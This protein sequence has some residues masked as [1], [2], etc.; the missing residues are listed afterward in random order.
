[1]E[2]KVRNVPEDVGIKLAQQAAKQKIS[3]EEY[4]RRILYSTSLNTSENNL[5]HF[6]TEVMQKLASQIEYT[7]K[8]LEMFGEK[9]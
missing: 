8:I 9:E 2:I 3:R 7:N 1:M 5:F 6:R 4:I